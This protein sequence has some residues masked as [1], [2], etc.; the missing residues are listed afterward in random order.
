M[1]HTSP[2]PRGL[3]CA[4]NTVFIYSLLACPPPPLTRKQLIEIRDRHKDNPDVRTLLLEIKQ[5][6][7]GTRSLPHIV[8]FFNRS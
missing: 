3:F 5:A 6:A 4:K 8:T 1:H 7:Q 2:P